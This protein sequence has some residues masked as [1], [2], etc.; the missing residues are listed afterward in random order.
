M[1][2]TNVPDIDELARSI[3]PDGAC[4]NYDECGN[5]VPGN[6]MMCGDCLDEAR[7]K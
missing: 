2:Q 4:V 5:T 3:A 1:T 6:G 7:R